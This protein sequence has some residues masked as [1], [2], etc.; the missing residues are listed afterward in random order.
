MNKPLIL[1]LSLFLLA[2]CGGGGKRTSDSLAGEG[3]DTLPLRH[4]SLLT[5][6]EH[7]GYT[8]VVVRN[9]WDTVQV[10]SRYVLAEHDAPLPDEAVEQGTV[11]RI[12][13]KRAVMASAVHCGLLAELG[14]L[15]R[16]AGVCDARYILLP[17][18]RQRLTDGRLADAGSSM[19]PDVE[20]IISLY[21]DALLFSPYEQGGG[22]GRLDKSGVPI[23]ECA[24]YMESSALG[25]AEWVR[26]YGRLFGCAAVADSLFAAV[27]HDYLLWR[28][29]AQAC[30]ER[31]VVLTDLPLSGSAWYLPGGRSTMGR[32]YADAGARLPVDDSTHSGSVPH[33][34]ETVYACAQDADCWLIRYHAAEDKTYASLAREHTAYARFRPFAER[35]VYGCNTAHNAFYEEV[36]FHPERLLAEL[37]S[38]FHPAWREAGE[39]RYYRELKD[40]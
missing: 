13:L 27:E 2:A 9:P 14:A 30:G 29:R 33:A 39:G 3:G 34:L 26:F 15:E 5:V 10:L 6:V 19:T 11:V 32:L 1:L 17:D 38:L 35:R 31:P 22:R 37:V 4:S 12:P 25:R 7:D 24:D 16:V 28:N 23:I 18:V 21:P 40:L 36:P 20:R 8:V